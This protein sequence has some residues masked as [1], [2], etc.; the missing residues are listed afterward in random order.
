MAATA[1]AAEMA[2]VAE[3]EEGAA[4]VEV[5]AV[6]TAAGTAVSKRKVANIPNPA[7]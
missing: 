1:E 7:I 2:E 5:E 4:I 6:K 3:M